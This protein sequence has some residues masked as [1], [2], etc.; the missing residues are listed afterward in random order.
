M[1][2]SRSYEKETLENSKEIYFK[3]SHP[4]ILEFLTKIPEEDQ[5]NAILLS[6]F[7]SGKFELINTCYLRNGCVIDNDS[8][9]QGN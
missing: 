2:I 9:A 6:S 3:K 4:K 8:S 5:K 7:S 1:K